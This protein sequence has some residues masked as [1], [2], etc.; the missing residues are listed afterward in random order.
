MKE[1]RLRFFP[2]SLFAIILGLSGLSIAY[3]KG[4]TFLGIP[5]RLSH[6]FLGTTILLFLIILLLM[7]Y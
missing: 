6:Y 7:E 1:N 3:Q 4:E 5:G 2:I